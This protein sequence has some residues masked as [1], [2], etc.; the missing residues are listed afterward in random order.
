[1]NEPAELIN[2]RL[3]RVFR[4]TFDDQALVLRPD[5]TASDVE[6]WDSLTHIDLIVAIEREFR[7]RFTTGEVA[8]LKN[9]G[10]L[11]SLISKKGSAAPR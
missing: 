7:I 3:T 10:E 9:V 1:M 11:E 6:N 5:M 4:D 8:G 2:E